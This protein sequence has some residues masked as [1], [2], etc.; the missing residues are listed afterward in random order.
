MSHSK[1]T[2]RQKKKI[3]TAYTG[4]T[5][6]EGLLKQ[7]HRTVRVQTPGPA[8]SAWPAT[9]RKHLSNILKPDAEHNGYLGI[10]AIR[11]RRETTE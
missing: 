1:P 10:C 5:H 6:T 11:K 4:E 9:R 8:A 3:N 2:D 7:E